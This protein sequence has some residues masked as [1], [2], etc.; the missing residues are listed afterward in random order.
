MCEVEVLSFPELDK[1][2]PAKLK[3]L[4]IYKYVESAVWQSSAMVSRYPGVVSN[5]PKEKL[6]CRELTRSAETSSAGMTTSSPSK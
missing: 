6:F 4:F 3:S 2:M 5:K 1:I